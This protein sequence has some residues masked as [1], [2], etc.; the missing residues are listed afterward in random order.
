MLAFIIMPLLFSI[1][2]YFSNG[3]YHI[4][5]VDSLFLCVT[6]IAVCGLATVDLSTLT[7]FQQALLFIQMFIGSPIIVSLVV[8]QSRKYVLAS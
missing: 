3:Q 4:S 5:Y 1:I 8:V 7:P 6:S 2:F